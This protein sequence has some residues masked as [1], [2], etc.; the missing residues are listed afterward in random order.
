VTARAVGGHVQ[1]FS[2]TANAPVRW[3]LLSA[4][5]REIG[6]G[7]DEYPDAE[8]CRV[9]VKVLQSIVDELDGIVRRTSSH[10]WAWQLRQDGQPI[11][12][13]GRGFDRLIRC[14]QGLAQFLRSLR[15]AH[16][17]PTLMVSDA[18]RW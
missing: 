7:V 14:E 17:G 3:R 15:D 12:L 5:N 13:S 2:Q 18:R 11:A 1:L 4:N 9:G 16:I 8:S 6:R 10:E